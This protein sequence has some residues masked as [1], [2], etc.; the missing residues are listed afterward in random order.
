[1]T[2]RVH[3][4]Q[5]A[6]PSLAGLGLTPEY[7]ETLRE[8]VRQP[9]GAILVCGPTESGKTTTLYSLLEE[10]DSAER[11]LTT[12]EDPIARVLPGVDQVEVDTL[13]GRTFAR[14]LQAILRADPDVVLVGEIRDGDTAAGSLQ[15][16]LSGRMVLAGLHAQS[17]AA[18][19]QR[20]VDLGVQPGLLGT[21][22][23]CVVAQRLLR[24][25]CR[26]CRE[27][28]YATEEELA[29]LGRITT[30]VG[31]RLLARGRGC[32]ACGETGFR[33]RAGV[34][35]ILPLTDDIRALVAGGASTTEIHE[36]AVATGMRTLRDDG[37]RLCLEGVTTAAEVQRVTGTGD[38]RG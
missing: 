36:A 13:A 15:A 35:E 5:T 11:A 38:N 10:L 19:V 23:T 7:E 20:L 18:A 22:L 6:P 4:E 26:D 3:G 25:V 27:T 17:A 28:Y 31:P 37:V 21:T 12:I 14:G 8:A 29:G 1:V 9:S 24:R 33:G 2:L 16:A 32:A 34:F 30:D